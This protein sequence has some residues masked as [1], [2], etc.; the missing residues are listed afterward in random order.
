MK[1]TILGSSGFIGKAL[2]LYLTSKGHDIQTPARDIKS[3]VGKKLGHVIY[4]IG[5]TGNFRDNPEAAIEA[6]VN[7]LQRLIKDADF[8]SWLYLSST[9]VYG[10][11]QTDTNETTE[12]ALHPEADKLYDLTKLLGESICLS[13]SN[14]AVRIARLSNVYG[15]GQS[16]H[17]FLGS[18]LHDLKTTGKAIVSESPNSS[19]DYIYIDDVTETLEFISLNGTERLYNVASGRAVTHAALAKIIESCGYDIKFSPNGNE[20][21]FPAID[22]GRINKEFGKKSHIILDDMPI[23]LNQR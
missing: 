14:P 19:K 16:V 22:T 10:T 4:A 7:V 3:L 21:V 8:E 13:Q 15:P 18:I 12:I 9:R 17:T 2:T 20:R 11:S 23:L 6:H 1:F 5:M